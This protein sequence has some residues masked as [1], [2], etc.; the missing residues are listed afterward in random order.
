VRKELDRASA[1][2]RDPGQVPPTLGSS[3]ELRQV[4]VN[5][6]VNAAQAIPPGG[7]ITLR[8]RAESG[9]GVV[10]V[11]DDGPGV[12]PE[13]LP[14]IFDPFYTTK[15]VGKGTG[16]GLTISYQLLQRMG[17]RIT[18]RSGPGRGTT[19]RVELPLAKP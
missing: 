13:A 4:L 8:T 17:G 18:V 7:T 19:F 16:L 3:S 15:E 11:E 2:R 9:C 6:L 10:E 1:L 5:L 12:A 14:Y